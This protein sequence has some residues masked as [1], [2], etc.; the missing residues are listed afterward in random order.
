MW[1]SYTHYMQSEWTL[2][3]ALHRMND[4]TLDRMSNRTIEHS[5]EQ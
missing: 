3:S 5:N 4:R 2:D 1:M